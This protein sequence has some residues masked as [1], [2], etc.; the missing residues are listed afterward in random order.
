MVANTIDQD[1][2]VD[3]NVITKAFLEDKARAINH[4]KDHIAMNVIEIGRHLAEARE[5][6]DHGQWESWIN[7]RCGLKHTQAKAY[8]RVFNRFGNRRLTA[9]LGI[10]KLNLLAQLPDDANPAEF[11]EQNEVGN[12]SVRELRELLK[13]QVS[14][15]EMEKKNIESVAY[16]KG[17]EDTRKCYTD[18]AEKLS[19]LG[20]KKREL[21]TL[22]GEKDEE[23]KRLNKRISE[24]F[25]AEK[26]HNDIT[27][28]KSTRASFQRELD[29]IRELVKIRAKVKEL[30]QQISPIAY[31]KHFNDREAFSPIATKSYSD[32]IVEIETWAVKAREA[33]SRIQ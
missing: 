9:D 28:L 26:I 16:Q 27:T 2:L 1:Q 29:E 18:I 25:E 22:I 30:L 5:M 8:I 14:L 31:M 15:S 12:K 21:E 24:G 6:C 32:I 4:L 7:D 17:A 20:R 33:L 10:E 11:I 23:L 3:T 13:S 19:E